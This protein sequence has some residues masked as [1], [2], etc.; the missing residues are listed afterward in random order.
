[1]ARPIIVPFHQGSRLQGQ[2][3]GKR[4]VGQKTRH[5]CGKVFGVTG[6]EQMLAVLDRETFAAQR[7]W[8]PRAVPAP[9]LRES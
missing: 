6:D 4:A 7:A 1:M 8:K 2:A 9:W 3:R 5:R